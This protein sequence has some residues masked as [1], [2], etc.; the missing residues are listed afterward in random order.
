MQVFRR[1][2]E[3]NSFTKAAETLGLPAS[4]VTSIVKNL[5]AHLGVRLLQRTTRRL[6][7]TSD[8]ATYYEHCRRIIDAIDSAEAGFPGVAGKPAGK[9]KVDAP[10]SLARA[11]LI[12]ALR[13]FRRRYPDIELT[14][15]LGDRPVDIVHEGVDCAIRT[16]VLADSS[17][18]VGRRLGSFEWIVAASPTY[19]DAF[20]EPM[21]LSSLRDHEVVGY[22]L[23]QTGRPMEWDFVVDGEPQHFQPTGHLFVNDTESYIACGVEG[24]GIVRAGNFLMLP[25]IEAGRLRRVLA[26]YAS[27]RVP[28]S[29][30]YA[31]NRHLAPTVRVFFDWAL[32]LFTASPLFNPQARGLTRSEKG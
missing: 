24:L 5:E 19:L 31:R 18:L 8:G 22:T 23:S 9:L 21:D 28:V 15:A 27:P 25:H 16:G 1:I 10:T 29:M 14:L 26:G 6:S 30:L 4:T 13:D 20:G 17:T 7:V 2:V 32:A 11:V 3:T 12:P